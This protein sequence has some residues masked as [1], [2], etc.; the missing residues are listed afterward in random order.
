MYKNKFL[1]GVVTSLLSTSLLTGVAA[2]AT[3][4]TP[5]DALVTTIVDKSIIHG[6]LAHDADGKL[7]YDNAGNAR[8]VYT[9]DIYSLTTDANSGE[10]KA[11]NKKIGEISGEAAFPPEFVA[12]SAGV[13]GLMSQMEAGTWDGNMPQMPSVVRWTCNHCVLNSA[14]STYVSLVDALDPSNMYY[15]AEMA[16]KF[17]AGLMD[18]SA[19]AIDNMRMDGRAFTGL[20]P[21]SFD[22]VSRTMSVR[23]AGCSALVGVSGPHAGKMGTLC[24]NST[25]TFNVGLAI[26]VMSGGQLVGY[27]PTTQISADGSSNCVT[28]LHT[29]TM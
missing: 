15:S 3:E 9:G 2:Y 29:P 26:P 27:E 6:S 20:T 16:A 17:D 10:L 12:L 21:A 1:K 13:N 19:G 11:I 4:L 5:Q 23:M 7:L 28:V 8:F 18:G 22:P 25:A 14:G 24:M